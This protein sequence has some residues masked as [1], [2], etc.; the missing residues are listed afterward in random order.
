V[1]TVVRATEADA[2]LLSG[3]AARTFVESHGHSA[4]AADVDAYIAEKYAVPVL[5]AEL[6]DPASIYHLAHVD[7]AAAGFSKVTLRT[8]YE[9]D[10]DADAGRLDRLYVLAEH[11]GSGAGAALMDH[12]LERMKREGQTGVWLHVWKGNPRAVRFYQKYG[13]AITGSHDF[14]LSPTHAN[15]NHRMFRAL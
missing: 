12:L 11:H 10:G 4:P 9:P 3:M 7:G 14:A 5:R 6:A 8:P 13:F 15:P 1:I 2:P